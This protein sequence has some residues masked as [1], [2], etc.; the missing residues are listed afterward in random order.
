MLYL[1]RPRS[2]LAY[3]DAEGSSKC[4]VTP[5]PEQMT[6]MRQKAYALH[7]SKTLSSLEMLLGMMALPTPIL[8]HTPLI[9]C[10]VGMAIMG[11]MAACNLVFGSDKAAEGRERIRLGIGALKEFAEVW[12]LGRRTNLEIKAICRQLL[13]IPN[14]NGVG[15][16]METVLGHEDEFRTLTA[17]LI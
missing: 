8:K 16:P 1:H 17:T 4:T 14:A 9:T 11:Q 12:P 7:T 3:S 10:G 2:R 15:T 13:N 5:P 6:R